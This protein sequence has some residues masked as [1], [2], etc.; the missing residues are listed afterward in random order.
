MKK[1][2]EKFSSQWSYGA[3]IV[4]SLIIGV[5]IRLAGQSAPQE[6][7]PEIDTMIPKGFVLVPITVQNSESL[8]S[9]F[10]T[11]GIVDLYAVGESNQK[12]DGRVAQGVK[13][14]RAP[15]N[16]SQFGVLVP[17]ADSSELIRQGA[18]FYVVLHHPKHVG[19]AIE[20]V[21][22]KA[23]RKIILE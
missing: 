18:N 4:T 19:T 2:R 1:W 6:I 13:L 14:L 3:L 5:F 23:K 12:K 20:K 16:P 22:P 21:R 15:K 10:G 7:L 17:D 9:V 8:D 11:F